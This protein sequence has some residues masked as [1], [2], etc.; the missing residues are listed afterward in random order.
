METVAIAGV[1]LIGGSFALA[2]RRAGFPG[3]I[4]GVSSA[5]TIEEALALGAIDEGVSLEEAA[6]RADLLYLAQPV[7][8]IIDTLERLDPLVR[9]ETLVTDA[10]STKR[11]IVETAARCL[12][13]C[14]FIGG[15]P[16]AGK[17]TRGVAVAEA[18]LFEGRTWV[19]TPLHPGDERQASVQTF[20]GW[21][22]AIGAHLLWM[23]ASEHDRVVAATSHLPQ[24]A[25][26][27]LAA[28]V[29]RRA[30]TPA[31]LAVAG[32]GLRDMTRLALSS[33]D[34]WR[35][36]LATNADLVGDTLDAYIAE[37]RAIRAG[38]DGEA[39]RDTFAAG[40]RLA[41]RLR[42]ERGASR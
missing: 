17:A 32:P 15:H 29:G 37:L 22:D 7:Q 1:G 3:R 36:I 41:R 30:E 34:L 4:L 21:L 12:K 35:D 6:A 18:G 16:M 10:G 9:P 14:L 31:S 23:D 42:G 38:L 13:R 11:R 39:A 24:V 8:V 40:E 33:Y 26:S 2:L 20:A 27:A 5:H 19:L 25:S 28:V